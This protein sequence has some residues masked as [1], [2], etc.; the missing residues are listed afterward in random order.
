MKKII[1]TASVTFVLTMAFFITAAV[2]I[3]GSLFIDMALKRG[4]L[5]DP[6][7]P[8]AVFRSAIEGHGK[9]IK[10]AE[11]P[12]FKGAKWTMQSFDGL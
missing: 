8:P 2:Y 3:A 5:G 10:K 7:A 1:L 9:A 12:D 11:R 4:T 6:K